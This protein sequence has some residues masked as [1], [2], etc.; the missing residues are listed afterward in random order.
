MLRS[1]PGWCWP[2]A[3]SR[4]PPRRCASGRATHRSATS[5]RRSPRSRSVTRTWAWP[6]TS[7][8]RRP[9]SPA[10]GR[11]PTRLART[12]SPRR[13]GTPGGFDAEVVPVGAGLARRAAPGRPD[14][15]AAGATPPGV[16]LRSRRRHRDGGQLVRRQR[17]RR[18]R[19]AGRRRDPSAARRARAARARHGHRGVDPNLPGLGLVPAVEQ[20]L[21]TAGLRLD[22]IDVVELNEAFAGQV[23]ACCDELSLDPERVCVEG[24]AL[25]LGHPWGASA[26]CSRCGCSPSSSRG[27]HGRYGARGHRGRRRPG[28]RDGGRAMPVIEARGVSHRYGDRSVLHD[29]DVRLAEQRIGIIGANGSGKSTFVRLLN[30]LVAADDG[31]GDRRRPRH[32]PRCAARCAD[33]SASASPTRTPRS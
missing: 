24:G 3:S 17:R 29:V 30:G 32:P 5:G 16:P 23:L 2:V 26:P 28:R 33:A 21:A 20:A 8:P 10:S 18:R 6:P 13:R 7:W 25:A 12:R 1:S 15:R 19:R 4:R 22:Q 31:H 27:G 11:T 14:R 9:G